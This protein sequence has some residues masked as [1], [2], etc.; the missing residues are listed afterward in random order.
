MSK[1]PLSSIDAKFRLILSQEEA[2]AKAV[3]MRI[4]DRPTI[5]AWMILIPI[6]FIHYISRYNKFKAGI[7]AFAREF[8]YTKRLALD[9]ALDSIKSGAQK[10]DA[11]Q[12]AYNSYNKM[13]I[14]DKA[15]GV[16]QK[17]MK[18]IE[19]L[20]DHYERLLK[21]EGA[22]RDSYESLLKRAYVTG[23]SYMQFLSQI[24][25]AEKEVS[26]AVMQSFANKE[27]DKE[28]DKDDYSEIIS[29]IETAVETLRDIEVKKIW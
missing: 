14:A 9:A 21:T 26:R 5:S 27:A 24:Q 2:F 19:L 6:L 29:R 15:A 18:E 28:A 12:R 11:I 17:Q 8:I 20:F 1:Y 23:F 16:R 10:P 4:L 25:K 3:A 7:E 22:E 13:G